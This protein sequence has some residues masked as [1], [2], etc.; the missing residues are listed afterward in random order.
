MRN[1][2]IFPN[3]VAVNPIVFSEVQT[4]NLL[5]NFVLKHEEKHIT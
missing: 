5:D 4:S 1:K 2:T 3:D